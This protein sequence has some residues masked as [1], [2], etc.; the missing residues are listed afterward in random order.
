MQNKQIFIWEKIAAEV[1]EKTSTYTKVKFIQ[2][3]DKVLIE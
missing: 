1:R 2:G 3:L